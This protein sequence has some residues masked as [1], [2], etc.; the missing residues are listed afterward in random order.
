MDIE[1]E[2]GC[3]NSFALENSKNKSL[4]FGIEFLKYKFLNKI[5]QAKTLEWELNKK[6]K[7][8]SDHLYTTLD[9]DSRAASR[10]GRGIHGFGLSNDAALPS[11]VLDTD[12]V[13]QISEQLCIEVAPTV[14]IRGRF[15][16]AWKGAFEQ[17][18]KEITRPISKTGGGGW[19]AGVCRP[20]NRRNTYVCR[21]RTK[22]WTVE[23][24]V[25]WY[26]TQLDSVSY[27]VLKQVNRRAAGFALWTRR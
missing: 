18:H 17:L 27:I 23:K 19:P 12:T 4:K 26:W 16:P 14:T 8:L 3:T 7:N 5:I 11:R 15:H 25:D 21:S 20:P 6:K 10:F 2:W 9:S 13:L 1:V 22:L 24:A